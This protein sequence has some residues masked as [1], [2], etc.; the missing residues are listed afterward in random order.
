MTRTQQEIDRLLD[1]MIV[2]AEK[3]LDKAFVERTK[4]I[5]AQIAAMYEKYSVEGEL[6][7]TQMS[8]YNRLTN[9]LE[10]MTKEITETYKYV[11]AA[12]Q[13]LMENQYLQNYLR[14]AFLYEYE[15]QVAMGFTVPSI[16]LLRAA[17]K[18]PIPKL[19]LPEI[20]KAHRNE[21]VNNINIQ[22]TQGLLAGEDYSRM[23]KRITKVVD[24]SR[25]K[26]RRVARTEA[27]RVRSEARLSAGEKASKFAKLEKVW[28]STL[29][30]HTRNSH[31]KLD[32]KK[33][34]EEG[35]FHIRG[36]KAKG[37]H[38]FF[39]ASEDVNCRCSVIY[40]VNGEYPEVRRARV[41]GKNV[42]I[43]YQSYEDWEKT[44]GKA[45]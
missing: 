36:L 33:A 12:I 13:E 28:S 31:R 35:Y 29:D 42:V 10:F 27:G 1:K 9:E 15:S 26:A 39:V 14:S 45:G 8:K 17:I 24:F 18:N 41:D 43:P 7:L 16:K 4:D 11:L 20:M 5:L 40:L 37:P 30:T 6:T 23:A 34:D 22:L 44:L 3:N 32:G 25:A 19:T 38:L 2:E 21:I